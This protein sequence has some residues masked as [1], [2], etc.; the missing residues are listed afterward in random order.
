MIPV[1]L[2]VRNFMPYR[3]KV[4]PLIFTGIHTA[5]IWGENG[6]GKSALIEAITWALWGKT[7]AKSDD[8]LIHQGQDEMEVEFDF[9]V[10]SE[11]YRVIRKHT[12]PK[13]N[14]AQD[15]AAWICLSPVMVTTKCCP[16][17]PSGKRNRKSGTSCTWTIKR[18]ITAPT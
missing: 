16:A 18:S 13:N 4:P 15:K 8:D 11:T 5:G 7:R 3:D 2:T 12:R 1:K 9:S 14:A 10:G 17:P 6:S